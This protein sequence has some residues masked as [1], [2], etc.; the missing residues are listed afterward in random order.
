MSISNK[1][2]YLVI[3]DEFQKFTWIYFLHSKDDL[4]E[5]IINHIKIVR[6]NLNLLVERIKSDNGTKF[7]NSTIIIFGEEMEIYQEF[8]A[9]RTPQ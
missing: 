2:Y 1:K 4:S 3:V 7:T 8:S 5:I 6:N 9:P